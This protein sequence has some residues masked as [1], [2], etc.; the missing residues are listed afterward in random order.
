MDV[1]I[2]LGALDIDE[3][4]GGLAA[5]LPDSVS[6]ESI[7]ARL[8]GASVKIS[9]AEARDSGS[10]WLVNSR[11]AQIG[12]IRIA[13]AEASAGPGVLRLRETTAFGTGHHATTALCIEVLEEILSTEVVD[14]VL[15][16]GTGSGILALAALMLGAER[17][18]GIDIDAEAL[19]AAAANARL[20][21][22][23]ERLDLR[24]G[25]PELLEGTWPLVVA[26][27]A[28]GPLME[29]APA[30]TR[31]LGNRGLV[32]FS[33]IQRSLEAEVRGAYERLGLWHVGSKT[34]A[35]WTALILRASW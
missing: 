29:M 3:A 14:R 4:Y 8:N 33:G 11:E 27:V 20:N 34:R 12:S 1:L 24:L 9:A 32:I 6:Q 25:G 35:G 30:L 17:V 26:N 19:L 21:G 16:V 23:A 15:D 7:A 13:P 28:P 18:V 31:R 22:L 10:V 5:I 2:E